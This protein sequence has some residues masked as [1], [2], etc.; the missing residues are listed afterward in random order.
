MPDSARLRLLKDVE[1][2][3]GTIATVKVAS[4]VLRSIHHMNVADFPA[5]FVV[6][7]DGGTVISREGFDR[8]VWEM[9]FEVW[10]YVRSETVLVDQVEALYQSVS[11]TVLGATLQQTLNT[12]YNA[13]SQSGATLIDVRQGPQLDQGEMPPMGGFIQPFLAIMHTARG[14][15]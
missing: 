7:T 2:A 1:T 11:N 3:L 9:P 5:T 4:R 14:S 6:A 13:N 15:L 10:G 12:T 8:L